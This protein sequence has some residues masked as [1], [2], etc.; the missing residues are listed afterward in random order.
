MTMSYCVVTISK[1]KTALEVELVPAITW[2]RS[3]ASFYKR[4]VLYGLDRISHIVFDILG[5]TFPIRR[6]TTNTVFVFA[7]LNGSFLDIRFF[8]CIFRISASK[9]TTF[10]ELDF[11]TTKELD[12][13]RCTTGRAQCLKR[14]RFRVKAVCESTSSMETHRSLRSPNHSWLSN[15]PRWKVPHR[16][17]D[18]RSPLLES[19]TRHNQGL[20]TWFLAVRHCI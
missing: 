16:K 13:D 10:G 7:M 18:G 14:N 12:V 15:S 6:E 4:T 1:E 11:F 3:S 17:K 5:S 8:N 9:Y 19:C 20:Q 2:P